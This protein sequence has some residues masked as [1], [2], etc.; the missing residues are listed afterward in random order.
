MTLTPA[1][2]LMHVSQRT[3]VSIVEMRGWKKGRVTEARRMY[4]Y[5]CRRDT[6]ASFPEI[7]HELGKPHTSAVTWYQGYVRQLER[8]REAA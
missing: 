7:G 5:L 4:A 6:D 8:E 1:A 2:I 3:G